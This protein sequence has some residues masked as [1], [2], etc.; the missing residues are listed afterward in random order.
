MPITWCLADPKIGEREV[1]LDLLTI[2]VETGLLAPGT[3]VLA[4]KNLAGRD[5]EGQ[6][7]RL[8]VRLLRPDRRDEPP[9]TAALADAA[10]GSN[11]STTA[12]KAS[13]AWN[14]TAAA[15][16]TGF[17]PESPSGCSPWPPPSGTTGPPGHPTSAASRPTTTSHQLQGIDHLGCPGS[18]PVFLA[19]SGL[20]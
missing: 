16:P 10:N 9:G 17:S 3:T 14:V 18:G 12:S 2:A 11:R 19:G 15:P 20:G 4:D 13:S 7:T 6:I 8:G 5:I 1:C